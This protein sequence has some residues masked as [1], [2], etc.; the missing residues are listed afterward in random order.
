MARW[1]YWLLCKSS[2][3][4]V[5][6]SATGDKFTIRAAEASGFSPG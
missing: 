1:V 2:A 5:A 4:D 3:H 6:V